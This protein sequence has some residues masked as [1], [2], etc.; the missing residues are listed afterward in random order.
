MRNQVTT[1]IVLRR[2]DYGEADKIV[3]ALTKTAGKVSFYVRGAR[4]PKSKLAGGIQ[5]FTVSEYTFMPGKKDLAT[6]V[7]AR[8][9][10][11]FHDILHDYDA[12]MY[13]YALLKAVDSLTEDSADEQYFEF[14]R[15]ALEGLASGGIP[16]AAVQFW[17]SM[18]LL[19][20]ASATPNLLTDTNNDALVE[21]INYRFDIDAMSFLPFDGGPYHSQHIKL[22]RLS[23]SAEHPAVIKRV[24]VD[25][26]VLIECQELSRLMVAQN[27]QIDL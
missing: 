10:E 8:M 11:E 3:L 27:L 24:Q 7:S 14:T 23:I 17:A 18:R 20:L 15:A 1:G 2:T 16:F 9:S 26:S 12:T 21:G 4:K 22:F 5:L 13:A 6:L 19:T 25:E